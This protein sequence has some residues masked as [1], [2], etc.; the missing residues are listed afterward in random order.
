MR[1]H[2]IATFVGAVT[3]YPILCRTARVEAVGLRRAELSNG[4]WLSAALGCNPTMTLPLRW[5]STTT[6][7]LRVVVA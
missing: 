1:D 6:I 4:L 2:A 3:L 5:S 7:D